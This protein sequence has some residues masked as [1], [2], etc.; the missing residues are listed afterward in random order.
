M[1]TGF[2][3]A[4]AS[5]ASV[6]SARSLGSSTPRSP[7]ACTNCPSFCAAPARKQEQQCESLWRHLFSAQK[8]SSASGKWFSRV[9]TEF[10][11]SGGGSRCRIERSRCAQTWGCR[12]SVDDWLRLLLLRMLLLLHRL[13]HRLLLLL[14]HVLLLLLLNMLLHD[15][16]LLLLLL[17]LHELLLLLL[18]SCHRG[19]ARLLHERSPLAADRVT[20]RGRRLSK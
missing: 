2:S 17:L 1:W 15:H 3:P 18:G 7:S 8:D 12:S 10:C 14:L 16:L 11:Q 20:R 5:S 4:D 6:T 13:L 19:L 9:R